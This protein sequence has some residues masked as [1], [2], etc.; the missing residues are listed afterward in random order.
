MTDVGKT[1]VVYIKEENGMTVTPVAGKGTV[2]DIWI[3]ETEGTI[4]INEKGS[5]IIKY[6]PSIRY[7]KHGNPY[8][9]LESKRFM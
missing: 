1:Y 5:T 8:A 6:Y 2:E 7:N 9:V 4:K 3:D